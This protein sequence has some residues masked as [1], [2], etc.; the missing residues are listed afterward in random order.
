MTS[1]SEDAET[2]KEGRADTVQVPEALGLG[3]RECQHS[4]WVAGTQFCRAAMALVS[5]PLQE[6]SGGSTK[7]ERKEA[8]SPG[9]AGRQT[10]ES[11]PVPQRVRKASHLQAGGRCW[12]RG[13]LRDLLGP[14]QVS[15]WGTSPNWSAR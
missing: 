7:T 12:Q 13:T 1:C 3:L 15:F 5:D 10:P 14:G 8:S 2:H 11:P 6:L 4:C 9:S